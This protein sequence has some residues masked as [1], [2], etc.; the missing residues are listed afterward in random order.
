MLVIVS[1]A[2]EYVVPFAESVAQRERC[3]ALYES[4]QERS[5]SYGWR[6]GEAFIEDRRSGCR[7]EA[8][9]ASAFTI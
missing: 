4:L 1:T 7:T 9:C 3:Q 2:G 6:D 8:C 5:S